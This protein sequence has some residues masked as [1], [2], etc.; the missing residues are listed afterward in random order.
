VLTKSGPRNTIKSAILDLS[1]RAAW[2]HRTIEYSQVSQ[3]EA[4]CNAA[5]SP[6]GSFYWRGHMPRKG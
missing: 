6:V 4:M 3:G 5:P 2:A 1:E